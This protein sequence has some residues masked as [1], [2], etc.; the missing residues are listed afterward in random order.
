[1]ARNIEFNEEVAIKKAMDVFW[2]KGFNGATM[3]DLTDAMQI[4]SSS[5]YNT[6]GDKRQ[7]FVKCI[8]NYTES[9]AAEAAEH[10]SK[11]RTPFKAIVNFINESVNTILYSTNSCL[12]IKT[13]FELASDDHDIKGILKADHDFT[14]AL[15]FGLVTKAMELG[16]MD[17]K[18][19]PDI[20]TE[21]IINCFTGW[22]ESYILHRDPVKIKKMAKYLIEH[23]SV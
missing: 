19:D 17:P 9:R 15:I 20:V 8:R 13:T 2:K 18:K 10:A 1:M 14:H 21:Y 6:I 3:R 16:E 23:L 22:Y 12:A 7:L 11:A 5:L 4:N